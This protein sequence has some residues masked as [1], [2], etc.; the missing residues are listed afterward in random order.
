MVRALWVSGP[1][2]VM[3]LC[4][5]AVRADLVPTPPPVNPGSASILPSVTVTAADPTPLSISAPGQYAS[6]GRVTVVATGLTGYVLTASAGQSPALRALS[7]V[8]N[9]YA[10]AQ[11]GAREVW[12]HNPMA[13]GY[14][15]SGNCASGWGQPTTA[16][17]DRTGL[18]LGFT[19]QSGPTVAQCGPITSD[20][21]TIF[22]RVAYD[23]TA[24]PGAYSAPVTFTVTPW[25]GAG[26][27]GGVPVSA[28]ATVRAVVGAGT[29]VPAASAPLPLPS[30]PVTLPS[31]IASLLPSQSPSPVDTSTPTPQPVGG[32]DADLTN[33]HTHHPVAGG[34]LP[35]AGGPTALHA[36]GPAQVNA[37]LVGSKGAL[38]P[39]MPLYSPTEGIVRPMLQFWWLVLAASVFVAIYVLHRMGREPRDETEP[40]A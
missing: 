9:D 33:R 20:T 39:F 5:V 35:A 8:I 36:G 12:S 23:G 4:P 24:A 1:I 31:P 28:T 21:E 38:N 7:S 19:T 2:L 14:S 40:Q 32:P 11:A 29:P 10:P 22:Y 27:S 34:T 15:A 37:V 25:S 30:L 6:S 3:G 16:G 18:Y 13:F 17:V 26:P